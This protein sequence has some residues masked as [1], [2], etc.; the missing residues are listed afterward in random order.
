MS[1]SIYHLIK[2]NHSEND[3]D[4]EYYHASDEEFCVS[5]SDVDNSYINDEKISESEDN[6]ENFDN[7]LLKKDFIKNTLIKFAREC[8]PPYGHIDFLLLY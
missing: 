4:Y 7:K 6:V 2:N 3:S 1:K 8:K 5:D